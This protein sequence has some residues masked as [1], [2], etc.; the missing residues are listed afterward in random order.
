MSSSSKAVFLSYAS[1]DA[2]AA[3]RICDTLR[4]AGVEVWFDQNELVGGDPWDTKIR[5]QIKACDLFMPVISANTQARAE[6]YFRLEWRLADQRTH[7]MGRTKSFL[8]PV[9]I[10]ATSDA[11]ADVPDSFGSVQWTRL[12]NGETPPAFTARVKKMLLADIASS[13]AASAPRADSE[14]EKRPRPAKAQKPAHYWL[15][16]IALGLLMGI[17]AVVWH[18]WSPRHP[19]TPTPLP[20]SPPV[21][22]VSEAK[23]LVA[24]AWAQ[25]NRLDLGRAE[26]E[27][28]DDYCRRA[29]VADPSD[30]DVW[31]AWS[32]VDAWYCYHAFDNSPER[33]ESARAKAARAL[34]LAP[35]SYESRL[36]QANFLVREGS[37]GAVSLYAEE[38]NRLLR[39]L[40]QERPT[41][42]RT[43]LTFALLQRNLRHP[44]EARKSLES[45]A[46][47][48]AFAALA[49]HE[50]AWVELRAGDRD[51]ALVLEGRSI[52][53]QP[54]W[55]NLTGKMNLLMD[56]V[57]DLDAAKAVLDQVPAA[58]MQ[59]DYAVA[60]SLRLL[61]TRREPD[62]LLRLAA[63]IPRDWLK[64]NMFRG[65]L[66]WWKGLAEQQAGRTAAARVHWEAAM[67]LVER[68]LVDA[69]SAWELITWKGRL[70]AVLGASAEAEQTLQVAWQMGGSQFI[71]DRLEEELL[72]GHTDRALDRMEAESQNKDGEMWAARL[73]LAPWLDALRSNARFQALQARLDADPRTNPKARKSSTE[74]ANVPPT[75]DNAPVMLPDANSVAVLAFANLSDDKANEYFSDGIS[76]ELL[77]VLAKIPRLKVSARTSAFYFKGKEVPIPEIAQKL[78]VAYVVEGSVRKA[79]DKV[80]ITAQLIKAIDGFH[81]WSDTFTRGLK[82]VFAVQDEIAGLIA[83]N[84]SLKM[85]VGSA[86][87]R[88]EVNPEAHRLVLEGRHF[89][90][91]RNA[92]GFAKGEAAFAKAIELDPEFAQAHAGLADVIVTRS[93]FQ[94]YG[95]LNRVD[96]SKARE[97]AQRALQLD[98]SLAEVYPS[99]GATLMWEGRTVEAEQ[100]F[101]KPLA[102]NPNYALA[103]HWYAIFLEHQGRLEEALAEIDQA[104]QLDPLAITAHSTR[105]RFL[106]SAQRYADAELTDQQVRALRS[107]FALNRGERA[108]GLLAMNRRDEALT[109]VRSIL[110]D[111]DVA[112]RWKNDAEA[113]FVLRQ[114]GHEDEASQHL[115]WLLARL[116]AET[117]L[118]GM[119]LAAAGRWDEAVPFLERI[120]PGLQSLFFWSPLWDGWR[121]DRRFHELLVKLNCVKA[122]E[123]AR[124]TQTRL[125]AEQ[126]AKR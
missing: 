9:C 57:G 44:D 76:E 52:A 30:A 4:A 69:P 119:A 15:P 94:S 77:N 89:W 54:A 41:E 8:M 66:G 39:G 19:A 116:P 45:L 68:R 111:P 29:S 73:R 105:E 20:D 33:R 80:R 58:A 60:V 117:Y 70:Y 100:Q 1:Q 88:R 25:M 101:Q 16:F 95:G 28:A 99:L 124:A 107:D 61:Y 84:L 48:P 17:I 126:R 21:L 46:Q 32:F 115:A 43:L 18:P 65:P 102:L 62:A 36:A 47:N 78:G 112:M 38:A 97:E 63:T 2:E 67:K 11:E 106:L 35:A 59:E 87:S 40:L 37:D 49:W 27:S 64:S 103:H 14:S 125:I 113:I 109:V 81:V 24:K 98:P 96:V 79:G 90:N 91:L 110:A 86:T 108:L 51:T 3:R 122:Y 23:Q 5:G 34:Q 53:L 26:L 123:V 74:A 31:A 104:I 55:H 50:L 7:L 6:G 56:W 22:P 71:M 13:A 120:P 114:T 12:P 121:Q 118:R 82:D 75:H 92:E 83:Q 42:P 10:D 93:I 72:V 85:G